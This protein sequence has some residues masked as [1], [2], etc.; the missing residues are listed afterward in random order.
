MP[1]DLFETPF[2][3]S[4][5]SINHQTFRHFGL[6][7]N[8]I[9][10]TPYFLL[11]PFMQNLQVLDLSGNRF[12]LLGYII[13]IFSLP[14]F[15]QMASLAVLH[16]EHSSISLVEEG[17]FLPLIRLKELYLQGNDLFNVPKSL[18]LPTLEKMD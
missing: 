14:V 12:D 6:G 13:D 10:Y 17:A 18:L 11:M 16:L 4:I 3:L 5:Q 2:L 8:D 9:Y 15:P 7:Q 1:F